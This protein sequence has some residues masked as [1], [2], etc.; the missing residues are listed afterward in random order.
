M[1]MM[2]VMMTMMMTDENECMAED[3]CQG[4]QCVNV[5]GS[6]KCLC[7]PGYTLSASGKQCQGASTLLTTTLR[8]FLT[9]VLTAEIFVVISFHVSQVIRNVSSGSLNP[10]KFSA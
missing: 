10:A 3:L 8:I 2:M 6:F 9:R 1:M 7:Q 4:G 5:D